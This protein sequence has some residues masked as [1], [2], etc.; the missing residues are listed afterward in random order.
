MSTIVGLLLGFIYNIFPIKSLSCL[1]Y[2]WLI[3]GY[4]PLNIL[5]ASP[6]MLY[7]SKACLRLHIS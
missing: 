3:G 1:L 4:D 5:T 7:A 2:I 6:L